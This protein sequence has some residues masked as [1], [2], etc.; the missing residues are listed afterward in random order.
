MIP[1]RS[2]LRRRPLTYFYV[3]RFARAYVRQL[4]RE[5]DVDSTNLSREPARLEK[6][7]LLQSEIEGRL[8]CYRINPEYPYLKP[9]LALLGRSVGVAPTLARALRR[10][11][12]IEAAC[13][14]G[15]FAK[16]QADTSSDID[17]LVIGTPEI[18]TLATAIARVERTSN[19]N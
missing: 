10:I 5:L 13:L 7:G 4:A 1:L 9:V 19:A 11:D 15:S 17:L 8:R 3:H 14:C 16:N 12:H 18:T 6:E 2:G